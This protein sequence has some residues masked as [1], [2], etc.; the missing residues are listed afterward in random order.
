MIREQFFANVCGSLL[1]GVRQLV[2]LMVEIQDTDVRESV[3]E[4]IFKEQVNSS[5]MCSPK[6]NCVKFLAL[7]GLPCVIRMCTKAGDSDDPAPKSV[8]PAATL[9]DSLAHSATERLRNQE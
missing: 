7:G 2:G 9:A 6:I 5:G 3:C 4:E 8:S 1:C